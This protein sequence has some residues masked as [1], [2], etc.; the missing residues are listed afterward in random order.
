PSYTTHNSPS[1]HQGPLRTTYLIRDRLESRK[2]HEL[3]RLSRMS[4]S[5][6]ERILYLAVAVVWICLGGLLTTFSVAPCLFFH[7]PESSGTCEPTMPPFALI[8]GFPLFV[9]GILG[10]VLGAFSLVWRKR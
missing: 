5:R 8:S 10:I 6:P 9:I 2:R 4:S 3:V 7:F 1:D